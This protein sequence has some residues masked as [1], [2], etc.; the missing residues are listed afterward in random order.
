M[1][2]G[3]VGL[4]VSIIRRWAVNGLMV[5]NRSQNAA[6]QLRESRGLIF[7]PEKVFAAS[8]HELV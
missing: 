3:V 1:I 8:T 4:Q 6:G 2:G 7:W 5:H